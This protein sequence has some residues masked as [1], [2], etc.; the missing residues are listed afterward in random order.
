MRP[1]LKETFFPCRYLARL[2]AAVCD[3]HVVTVVL[4]LIVAHAVVF[5]HAV[6]GE[7]AGHFGNGVLDIGNPFRA[8]PGVRVN[9]VVGRSDVV[10]YDRVDG[11]GV[12]LVLVMVVVIGLLE[13]QGPAGVFLVTLDPPAVQHAEMHD[14]VHRGLFAGSSGGFERTRRIVEPNVHPL[15][16]ALCK[17]NVV[18]GDEYYLAYEARLLGYLDDLLD[19]VLSHAVGRMGLPA[20]TNW[21]GCL[22]SFTMASRRSRSEKSK[23]ARL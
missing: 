20:N 4:G 5:H 17:R 12:E 15:H 10:F 1:C 22:G 23:V 6:G 3:E 11:G 19:Q 16:H 7:V 2:L 8:A 14:A 18:A 13:R 21:T 9:V